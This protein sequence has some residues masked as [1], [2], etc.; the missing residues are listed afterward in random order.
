MFSIVRAIGSP[1]IKTNVCA[2]LIYSE[3]LYSFTED[4]KIPL[5][6]LS[7]LNQ[8]VRQTLPVY[9]Y[10]TVRFKRL[11]EIACKVSKLFNDAGLKYVIFKT[12]R[13]FPEYVSDVDILNM[14][15]HRDYLTMKRILRNNNYVFMEK[16]AFCTTFKD[17][18]TNFETEA[19]IDVYD[20]ISV[21]RLIYLDKR[22]LAG[23]MIPKRLLEDN[24][25]F[26]FSVEA[27][28]LATIAHAGLKENRYILAEYYATLCYLSQMDKATI[29]RFID[30]VK[31]NKL[32]RV[33]RWHLSITAMIHEAVYG[34]MPE[35]LV[36]LLSDL[37]GF[38]NA[39]LQ[40][41]TLPPYNVT[42][43]TL[44]LVMREKLGDKLFKRSF[45]SQLAVPITDG[46]SM[47]R[48]IERF[49]TIK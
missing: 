8:E 24:Q 34:I 12:L 33:T 25:T 23:Y 44:A 14:G 39:S 37:G 5:T 42:P 6:F 46:Y 9:A 18:E 2:P 16:G 21:N 36:S 26:V 1:F 35:V 38:W 20:E 40:P 27:E 32:V 3:P 7:K 45:L 15:S 11:L 48:I 43:L 41:K 4:N 47:R 13:P 31:D 19:M 22:S 49:N 28:L 10:H 30:L 17:Y 29:K